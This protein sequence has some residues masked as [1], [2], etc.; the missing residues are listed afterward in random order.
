MRRT[1]L[2]KL[3]SIQSILQKV[4]QGK[5]SSIK[6]EELL[7]QSFKITSNATT[8]TT[9][10]PTLSS[11]QAPTK[12][13]PIGSTT[14]PLESFANLDHGRSQRTGFPE[15]IFAAGKTPSQIVSILDNMAG[16]V[17][18]CV[19]QDQKNPNPKEDKLDASSYK[20]IL[21]TRYVLCELSLE[22]YV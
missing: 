3:P 20:A 9:T 7:T 19:E 4:E 11:K 12:T 5:I 18:E 10:T 8:T 14:E 21:A 15:A 22:R 2:T 6:A 1:L 13:P 16:H 17:N